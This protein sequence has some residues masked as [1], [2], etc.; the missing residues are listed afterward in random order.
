MTGH[1]TEEESEHGRHGAHRRRNRRHRPRPRRPLRG[2]GA[3]G[4]A[5]RP[6]RRPRGGGGAE[7]GGTTQGI[8]LDLADPRAIAASLAGVGPVDH[9]VLA[10]IDRDANTVADYD[11]EAAIHLVTL[12]LVGYTEVVHA[13]ASS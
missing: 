8:A 9:V 7:I 1:S 2:A 11:I 4:R 5:H 6:G 13:C 3:D 10:A 12:K